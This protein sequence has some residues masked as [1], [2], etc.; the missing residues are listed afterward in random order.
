LLIRDEERISHDVFR[1]RPITGN[2]KGDTHG[3]RFIGDDKYGEGVRVT[4][5]EGSYRFGFG[6]VIPYMQE[7]ALR[8]CRGLFPSSSD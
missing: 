7:A 8:V 1:L 2:G 3:F 4:G 5:L 6:H